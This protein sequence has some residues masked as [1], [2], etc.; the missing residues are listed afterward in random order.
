MSFLQ[1]GI[2]VWGQTCASYID[3]II[4]LQRKAV[5]IISSQSLLCHTTPIFKT[6][7]LLELPDIFK[8]RL[9]TFVFESLNTLAPHYFHNYFSLNS[10]IHSYE[11][12]HSTRGDIYVEKKNTLQFGLRSI[13][14]MG[15]KLWNDLPLEVRN[16]TS[17]FLFKRKLKLYLQD[18]M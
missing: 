17:K 5:K 3:P 8:L 15:E 18:T 14:Y 10:S 6:L 4:K 1:Y 12:R 7:K 13:R 11:T 16:S 2:T 9:L